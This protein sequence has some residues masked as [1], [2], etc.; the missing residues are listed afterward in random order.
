[1]TGIRSSTK[2]TGSSPFIPTKAGT[3]TFGFQPPTASAD[4]SSPFTEKQPNLPAGRLTVKKYFSLKSWKNS[5]RVNLS[6]NRQADIRVV[7]VGDALKDLAKQAEKTVKDVKK[8]H[9][10]GKLLDQAKKLQKDYRFFL[11]KF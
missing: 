4:V 2:K 9:G 1:M 5:P 10:K 8:E 7:D 11:N 3:R 6:T